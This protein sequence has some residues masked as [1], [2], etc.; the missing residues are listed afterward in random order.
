MSRTY[1][2][3]RFKVSLALQPYSKIV[4]AHNQHGHVVKLPFGADTK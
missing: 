3:E 2:K 1:N 4:F